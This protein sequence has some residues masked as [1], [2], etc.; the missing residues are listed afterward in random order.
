MVELFI[1]FV[2]ESKSL[3]SFWRYLEKLC[4]SAHSSLHS[5][6]QEIMVH[7]KKPY[8]CLIYNY[9]DFNKSNEHE[10]VF[11]NLRYMV[12][13]EMPRFDDNLFIII[14]KLGNRINNVATHFR[15]FFAYALCTGFCDRDAFCVFSGTCSCAN[16]HLNAKCVILIFFP[17]NVYTNISNYEMLSN[18]DKNTTKLT[19]FLFMNT[20]FRRRPW[21]TQRA[22]KFDFQDKTLWKTFTHILY[23]TL[24]QGYM[25]KTKPADKDFSNS[26]IS[27]SH[28]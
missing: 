11:T 13:Y 14:A 15:W 5:T 12:A 23:T 4:E 25:R 16:N 3:C 28:K 24:D 1:L 27:W 7:I 2:K 9:I 17:R 19:S 22:L 6:I 20:R 10:N 18:F 21:V 8:K 26:C